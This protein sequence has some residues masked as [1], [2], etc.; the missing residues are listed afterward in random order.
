[1][2]FT[3]TDKH[4]FVVVLEQHEAVIETLTNFCREQGIENGYFSGIGAVEAVTCGFYELSTREYHFTDYETLVEVV[5]FSGNIMQKDNQ[6]FIHAHGIFTD[7]H[8][9][10]FGGHIQEM[11]VGVTLE[12]VVE[13][14]TTKL[15]RSY[16]ENTGLYLIDTKTTQNE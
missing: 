4:R 13:Q 12:L 1:M 9:Q 11:R 5:S 6:P 15:Y 2:Q 14:L 10:A 3:H 8:N 7:D 16:D